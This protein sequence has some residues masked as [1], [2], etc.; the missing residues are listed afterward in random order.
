MGVL[1]FRGTNGAFAGVFAPHTVNDLRGP[2]D[3]KFGPDDN[4]YV[5]SGLIAYWPP[6]PPGSILRYNGATGAFI[7][8][9][10]PNGSGGLGLPIAFVFGPDGNLYV[11]N[12]KQEGED[13]ADRVGEVLRFNG[14]TGAFIDVFIPAE[15][16]F[17]VGI[18][19]GPDGNL[20]VSSPITHRIVR[21]DGTSGAFIDV[22]IS[23]ATSLAC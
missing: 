4:L 13:P 15:G 20:Y 3:V 23:N 19:F 2:G 9:F 11:C 17:W 8:A 1:R 5:G 21:F 12:S 6:L 18:A 7:D 22:F 16:E 10:V 14:A